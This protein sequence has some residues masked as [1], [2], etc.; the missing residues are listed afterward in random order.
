MSALPHV[1]APLNY[2][3]GAPAE[4]PAFYIRVPPR[5]Q[6]RRGPKLGPRT[7]SI[8]DARTIHAALSLDREGV[9]L[10]RQTS[11]VT[12]F[13]DSEV[14]RAH[15]YPE[16]EALVAKHTGASRVLAFD[17][18]LRSIA[19]A[20]RAEHGAQ[21]PVRFAHNDYTDDSAPQRVRD[22]LPDEADTLLARRF[23]VINVWRP[24]HHPALATPLAVCD[25]GTLDP[26]D[27][28]TMDLIY[29]DRV[30]EV[31]SLR[32]DLAHRWLY[33]PSMQPDEVLLLKC[34]DS[35]RDG[36]ARFTAHTAFDDPSTPPDAPARESVEV[37]TL[38]FFDEPR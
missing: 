19:L 26:D 28:V 36:R 5:E 21:M 37:R 31:Q 2:L 32:F 13:Y 23:A 29:P 9:V 30:G 1:E 14:V 33:F 15:Y 18:N 27:L 7:V 8:H 24:I 22:L 34:Y 6:R 20:G 3:E 12:D 4:K 11:A 38:A 17:H 10:V 25:A 35:A 16:M